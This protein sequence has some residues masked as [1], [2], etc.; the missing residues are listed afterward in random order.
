MF[1]RSTRKLHHVR[2]SGPVEAVAYNNIAVLLR[3]ALG[4]LQQL[5]PDMFPGPLDRQVFRKCS[6]PL[7]MDGNLRQGSQSRC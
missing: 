4:S 5:G 2:A 3:G 7:G 6:T 1:G